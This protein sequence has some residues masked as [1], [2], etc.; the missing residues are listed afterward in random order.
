MHGTQLHGINKVSIDCTCEFE[1][2]GGGGD[3]GPIG[4]WGGGGRPGCA[5]IGGESEPAAT[6]RRPSA[7]QATQFQRLLGALVGSQEAPKLVETEMPPPEI[8]ATKWLPSAED[9]NARQADE[10]APVGVQFVPKLEEA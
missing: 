5:S 9:A 7:E 8:T 2:I 3:S 4:E 1:T 10:A 6:R